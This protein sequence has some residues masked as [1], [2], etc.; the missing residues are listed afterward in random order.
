M[1]FF[2]NEDVK[3]LYFIVKKFAAHVSLLTKIRQG[4]L[5]VDDGLSKASV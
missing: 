5:N 1:Q 4:M 2:S 3:P